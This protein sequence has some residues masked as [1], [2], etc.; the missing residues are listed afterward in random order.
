MIAMDLNYYTLE[1]VARGRHAEL[2]AEAERRSQAQGERAT[3]RPLLDALG[4]ALKR[5]GIGMLTRASHP[6]HV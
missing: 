4:R 6:P 1:A 5:M 2:Q 3:A